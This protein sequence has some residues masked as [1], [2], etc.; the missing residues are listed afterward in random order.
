[1]VD[2]GWPALAISAQRRNDAQN[3]PRSPAGQECNAKPLS[4]SVRLDSID[5][6]SPGLRSRCSPRQPARRG[7]RHVRIPRPAH[8]ILQTRRIAAFNNRGT[9]RDARCCHCPRTSRTTSSS[10]S[11][12]GKESALAIATYLG[13]FPVA[14]LRILIV[15]VP[16]DAIHGMTWGT[17]GAATRITLGE[18]AFDAGIT[19]SRGSIT[20]ILGDGPTGAKRRIVTASKTP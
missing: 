19:H 6:V 3:L 9:R 13:R 14:R 18:S 5:D 1:M 10:D 17:L 2:A 15:P 11:R 12:L 16:G 20:P 8:A 7:G 4:S